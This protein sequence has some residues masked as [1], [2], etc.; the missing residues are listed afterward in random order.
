MKRCPQGNRA[1]ECLVNKAIRAMALPQKSGKMR[2]QCGSAALQCGKACL[3]ETVFRYFEAMPQTAG[4]ACTQFRRSLPVRRA[5]PHWGGASRN[6]KFDNVHGLL[7]Q[8]APE[9]FG[10]P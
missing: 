1:Q 9:Y 7:R 8:R 2:K 10:P 4:V 5:L 6:R 3:S